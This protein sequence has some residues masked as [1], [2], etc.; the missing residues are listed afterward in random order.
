MQC[1]H[2][3]AVD[4]AGVTRTLLQRAGAFQRKHAKNAP[5]QQCKQWLQS[6]Y[7]AHLLWCED[8][9]TPVQRRRCSNLTQITSWQPKLTGKF[10]TK[11]NVVREFKVGFRH[12]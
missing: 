4:Q 2:P 6:V 5:A 12:R 10:T 8:G 11:Q 1:A 7:D 9:T 3:E